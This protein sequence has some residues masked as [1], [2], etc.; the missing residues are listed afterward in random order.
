MPLDDVELHGKTPQKYMEHTPPQ[1]VN[2]NNLDELDIRK[3]LLENYVMAKTVLATILT[4]EA[5]EDGVRVGFT[6]TPN[7]IATVITAVKNTLA[8][9]IKLQT[10]VYN[11][12]R[13]KLI[14]QA[15]IR[16]VKSMPEESRQRFM[17]DYE[18]ILN[19]VQ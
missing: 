9:I 13:F 14:E 3:E 6:D 16:A 1:A 7:Q 5:V 4:T 18:K 17:D 8:D 12:E 10:D 11:A 2:I 19:D 15:M